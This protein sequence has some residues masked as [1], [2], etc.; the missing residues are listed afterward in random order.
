MNSETAKQWLP[1]SGGWG[2][3]GDL[4]HRVQTSNQKMSNF[5]GSNIQKGAY[6]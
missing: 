4:G 6:S 5:W 2:K 1:G 3:R